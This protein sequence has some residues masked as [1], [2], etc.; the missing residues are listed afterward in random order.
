VTVPLLALLASL[1]MTALAHCPNDSVDGLFSTYDGACPGAS[2]AVVKDGVVVL[3]RAYGV[4]DLATHAPATP[5]TNYR[6]ASVTKQFTAMSILLLAQRGDLSIDDPVARYLPE[7][8]VNAPNLTLRHLLTHTSGLPEYDNLLPEDDTH[9][10]VDRD[11]LELLAHQPKLVLFPAPGTE[12]HYN[13]TGYALLA[14]VVERV[15][16]LSYAEF[17]RRNIFVPLGMTASTAYQPGAA[18]ANRAYGY[19]LRNGEFVLADQTRDTAVLG[20]GG[21]Y[22]STRDLARWIDALEHGRL[23]DPKRLAEATSPL[24]PTNDAT[25]YG[26]G[27]RVSAWNGE[28]LVFHTGVSSGFKNALLW[29]PSRRLAVIVLSNRRDGEVL[30]LARAVLDRVWNF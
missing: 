27:W 26:F 24:V 9:Q 15:S 21:I 1:A 17:L 29:V 5:Q 30:N 8:L 3:E 12:H 14:L 18:I 22:S 28:K 2:V 13:N 23:L 6:L 10:I 20:D 25:S 16:G 19:R 11:V 4:A 7:L